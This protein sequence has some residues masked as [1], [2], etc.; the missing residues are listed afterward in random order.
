MVSDY[1]SKGE[2]AKALRLTMEDL[3][4]YITD[5]VTAE[6]TYGKQT[7]E[8]MFY[9]KTAFRHKKYPLCIGDCVS[10]AH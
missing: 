8:L 6:L 9:I 5:P 3:L 2:G 7:A 1:T 10:S 4:V